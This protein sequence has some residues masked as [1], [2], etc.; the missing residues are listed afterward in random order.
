LSYI[1]KFE[2]SQPFCL[3][4]NKRL[5]WQNHIKKRLSLN[6]RSRLLYILLS[7]NK[8]T[9]LKDSLLISIMLFNPMC[10]YG[11][12]LLGLLKKFNLKRIQAFHIVTLRK[13]TNVLLFVSNLTLHKDLGNKI[14]ESETVDC[15]NSSLLDKKTTKMY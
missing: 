8:L 13:I 11:I 6:A 12:Q 2:S 9:A 14:L 10:L 1:T 3:N 5:T 4:L 7:K 15:I